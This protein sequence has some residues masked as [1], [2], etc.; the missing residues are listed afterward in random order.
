MDQMN[1]GGLGRPLPPR[2]PLSEVVVP[3][4]LKLAADQVIRAGGVSEVEG[5][6]LI[7]GKAQRLGDAHCVGHIGGGLAVDV[8]ADPLP[9]RPSPCLNIDHLYY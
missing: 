8:L 5:D 9:E 4:L 3:Q 6:E 2:Q 1:A 7:E